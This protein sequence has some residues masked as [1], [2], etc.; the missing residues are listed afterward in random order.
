[1]SGRAPAER[2]V[3][4]SRWNERELEQKVSGWRELAQRA[5]DGIEV[6]LMWCTVGNRV[7]IV[8]AD[9]RTGEQFEVE[10]RKSEALSAFY[11]PFAQAAARRS[12]VAPTPTPHPQD[13]KLE[14]SPPPVNPWDDAEEWN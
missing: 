2:P 6:T 11:H 4:E 9:E 10:V 13:R 12:P 3:T 1:M 5:D 8:V 14:A 7:K